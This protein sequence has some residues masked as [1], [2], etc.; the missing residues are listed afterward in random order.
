MSLVYLFFKKKL[1]IKVY[2]YILSNLNADQF[3]FLWMKKINPNRHIAS[4]NSYSCLFNNQ[5][6][7]N[8]PLRLVRFN[9]SFRTVNDSYKS[10]LQITK[11]DISL[12]KYGWTI[13]VSIL[14][15]KPF[16]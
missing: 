5:L 8:I 4:I 15:L 7:K 2:Y 3:Y 12:I 1:I 6:Q 11:V 13:I 9:S 16:N 10:I 14:P